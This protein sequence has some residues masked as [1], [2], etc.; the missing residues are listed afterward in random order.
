M[1]GL[2]FKVPDNA[3]TAPRR[4]DGVG[5]AQQQPFRPLPFINSVKEGCVLAPML[6]TIFF[7]MMLREAKEKLK[8][9]IST[10][11]NRCEHF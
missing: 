10:V 11:S 5:E 2:P 4:S 1:V 6:F 9:G 3:A 7:S 8:E